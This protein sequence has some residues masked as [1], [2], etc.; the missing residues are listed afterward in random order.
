MP[1]FL[2][3]Y[4]QSTWLNVC[5]KAHI[6]KVLTHFQRM[7]YDIFSLISRAV[8]RWCILLVG[9]VYIVS[10]LIE[11]SEHMNFMKTSHAPL[12]VDILLLVCRTFPIFLLRQRSRSGGPC[13]YLTHLRKVHT[14]CSR[15][16]WKRKVS[17]KKMR[18]CQNILNSS[19]A[20]FLKNLNFFTFLDI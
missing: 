5:L 20:S 9:A 3:I 15:G 17:A 1:I 6:I 16:L 2:R 11:I 10:K 14:K 19:W 13:R 8:I 4:I 12:F 7:S 18:F